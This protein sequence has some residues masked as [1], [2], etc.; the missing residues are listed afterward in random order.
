MS[1]LVRASR[2]ILPL[3]IEGWASKIWHLR[4]LK[5][6]SVSLAGN[7]LYIIH[8][9]LELF[10]SRKIVILAN[11]YDKGDCVLPSAAP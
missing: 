11:P 1:P 8:C 9:I 6:I 7:T 10:I 2:D 3:R 4:H 5:S